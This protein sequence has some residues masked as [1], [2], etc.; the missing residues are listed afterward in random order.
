MMRNDPHLPAWTWALADK[1]AV[2]TGR[3]LPQSTR[4]WKS[5]YY[6][7]SGKVPNWRALCIHVFGAPCRYAPPEG[8]DH[9][10]AEV[11]VEG[12]FVGIQ[13]PMAM[14]IRKKDMKLVSV[15]TKKLHVYESMCCGPLVEKGST[16]YSK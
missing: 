15:S 13:H 8:P 4:E 12:Y 11:T 14:V 6:L 7:S 9:K 10:R 5:A 3:Y 16:D 2:Y 1:Y